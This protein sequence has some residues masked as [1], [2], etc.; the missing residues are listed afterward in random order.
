MGFHIMHCT[1]RQSK[2]EQQASGNYIL[3]G[4]FTNNHSL[5]LPK[6]FIY[7]DILE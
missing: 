2:I 7:Q 1:K 6:P 5:L 3:T 4:D